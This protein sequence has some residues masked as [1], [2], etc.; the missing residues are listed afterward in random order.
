[1]QTLRA[2]YVEEIVVM[3]VLLVVAGGSRGV[4]LHLWPESEYLSSVGVPVLP[5][6]VFSRKLV[7]GVV[8]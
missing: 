5:F 1:M 6:I 4:A 8:D 7:A 3:V 2:I